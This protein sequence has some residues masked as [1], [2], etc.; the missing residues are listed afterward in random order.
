MPSW[1]TRK[2]LQIVFSEMRTSATH[3]VQTVYIEERQIRG[4]CLGGSSVR[5]KKVAAARFRE[6]LKLS[7]GT[8]CC[9]YL[10]VANH[11]QK[12]SK[13]PKIARNGF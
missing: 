2:S 1:L 13:T 7:A 9:F 10:W 3:R 5:E 12:G 11:R 4:R 6:Q 8:S